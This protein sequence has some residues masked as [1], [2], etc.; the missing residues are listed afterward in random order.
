M[1]AKVEQHSAYEF[2]AGV[3]GE[4]FKTCK[5]RL[6]YLGC[7]LYLDARYRTAG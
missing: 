6:A 3:L 5:I 7:G 4:R 1:I 2:L